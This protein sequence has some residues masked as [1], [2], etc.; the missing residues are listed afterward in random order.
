M[1]LAICSIQRDRGPWIKEWIE[2]HKIV[3]FEKFYIFLHNCT[4]NSSEVIFELSKK[5][6]ISAFI[7]SND[8]SRPQLAVYQYCYQ[9]FSDLHS[10]IA[11]IDGDE[12]L[13]SPNEISILPTLNQ[14]NQ[15]QLSAIGVYWKCFGS[16]NHITEPNGLITE[17][18][19][20]R[21]PNN[22]KSNSHFK[23]IVK[24]GEKKYFSILNNAHYF[25][26][27]H[28]TYDTSLRELSHGLTNNDPC[29]EKLIINHY[30][31]QSRYYF[32]KFKKHSGGADTS[33]NLVRSEEWWNTYNVND[34]HDDSLNHLMPI[35][36]TA[37]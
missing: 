17:N 30:A 14:F 26:T 13:Y 29:Y 11:F 15:L 6:D 3:G 27:K 32:E 18:Y 5:H 21:A 28:G 37:L 7:V 19:R 22:F 33:P 2:F 10:W 24:G 23:S 35:L 36:K 12:F 9:N 1:T 31:T 8:V 25:R 34:I 16:S 20:Y 4:D